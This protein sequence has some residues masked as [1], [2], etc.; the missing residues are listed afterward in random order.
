M[1]ITESGVT[2]V[3]N[4]ENSDNS[5]L[6]QNLENVPDS[7][8]QLNTHMADTANSDS[9]AHTASEV[10]TSGQNIEVIKSQF[11]KSCT[12]NLEVDIDNIK[13]NR[14]V[15]EENSIDVVNGSGAELGILEQADTTSVE[16]L[17]IVTVVEKELE[18]ASESIQNSQYQEYTNASGKSI[19]L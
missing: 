1:Q 11:S 9:G 2:T 13:T 12:E 19:V 15:I 17:S 10:A 3:T 7:N 4:V 14:N 8:D 6:C 18:P 16:N 5:V